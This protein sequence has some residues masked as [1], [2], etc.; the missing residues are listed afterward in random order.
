MNRILA[1]LML[2][3]L[4]SSSGFSQKSIKETIQGEWI[5]DKIEL[6]DGSSIYNEQINQ[7]S[8]A[9]LFKG[10]SLLITLDGI[11]SWHSY[12]IFDST[13]TF[14]G[15]YYR[16]LRL[17]KPILQFV[18]ETKEEGAVPLRV[19][20]TYK[21]VKDL[22]VKPEVYRANNGEF[23]YRFLPETI[24]PKFVGQLVSP[25]NYIFSKFSFP[26]YKK[27]GFVVRFVITKT[28][29]MEGLRIVAS[30]DPKYDNRLVSA[31]EKTKGS[32]LPA[33]YLGENVN[34]EIEYN[35]D[36][37]GKTDPNQE[38]EYEKQ[39][40]AEENMERAKSYYGRKNYKYAI[41]YLDKVIE[42]DAYKIDAYYLRAAS[43]IRSDDT[44]KACKDYQ[45]LIFLD[46]K[47]AQE[48]YDKYCKDTQN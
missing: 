8:Y 27:G 6:K 20:L 36:L 11:S 37:T 3:G 31:V 35:Y 23:V 24:E 15:N 18:Q 29:Q 33:T 48:Q 17:E 40:L 38:K 2:L 41:Y 47:T 30:S 39:F 1:I 12:K 16:I 32:W 43:Y 4:C 19:T 9:L 45:Q 21:P 13:L 7:T 46:Q 10:D 34:C 28:G 44:E 26:E 25:M 14:A 5:K 42:E 22:E